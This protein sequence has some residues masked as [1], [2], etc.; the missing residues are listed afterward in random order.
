M[1]LYKYRTDS[2]NTE[3]IF[4]NKK[5][6]LSNAE[7]LNDPFECTIQ[8]IAKDW[9]ANKIKEGKSAH[10]EGF[11]YGA[12]QSLKKTGYFYN[13]NLKQSTEFLKKFGKKDFDNQYKTVREFILRKTGNE[14]SNPEETY[15]NFDQQLNEVGIF[16]LSE[17]S[18][19]PLMWAHYADSSRGIAIGFEVQEGAKLSNS[20]HCLKVN[21]SNELPLFNRSGFLVEV[22]F[23]ATGKNIQK[24]SFNDP[25]LQLAISTKSTDWEY[26]KEWRYVEEKSGAYN[27]PGKL[28]EIVF[29]VNCS[30]EIR[31]KYKKLITENFDYIVNFYEITKIPNTNQLQK[32]DCH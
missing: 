4:T 16:S 2:E 30:I 26:E 10:I 11:L 21:Y 32:L 12:I 7:G 14:I 24:I 20:E 22:G 9:I 17:T 23:Y 13:L 6:W 29:G 28:K 18:N 25:T 5:V 27:F 31:E 8:E 1:I 3:K 19:N 15:E